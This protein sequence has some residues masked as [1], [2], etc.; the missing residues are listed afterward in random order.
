MALGS[1]PGSQTQRASQ[2][3]SGHV[4]LVPIHSWSCSS[5]KVSLTFPPDLLYMPDKG[6]VGR[7][8][9]GEREGPQSK[10]E[11]TEPT[12]RKPSGPDFECSRSEHGLPGPP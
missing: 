6:T 9:C 5:L 8:S 2:C 12:G 1:A 4:P 10:Q 3:G 11:N 7:R